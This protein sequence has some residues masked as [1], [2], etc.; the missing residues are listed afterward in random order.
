MKATAVIGANYGDEG[1]GR[2]VEWLAEPHRAAVLVVRSNGGAQAGHTVVAS[3]G[4]RHV[5]HHFGS[6]TLQG[7]R[8]HLSRFMVS[9]PIIFIEEF[10]QLHS[11]GTRPVVTADPRGFVTTPWDMMVNQAL[12]IARGSTRHGSCG[13]GF[14]ETVERCEAS[15]HRLSVADLGS[16]ELRGKLLAIRDEW[17]PS[18]LAHLQLMADAGP[19][20]F[21]ASPELFEAFLRQ[22]RQFAQWVP[23]RPDAEIGAEEIVIFEGAQGLL[24]DQS[25]SGFPY[26]TRSNTGMANIAVIAAE[27]GIL[28]VEPLYVTRCYLTRHGRGPMEDER[29]VARW[30]RTDDPTNCPNIW[31]ESLRFGLLDPAL[32]ASRIAEDLAG[33]KIAAT[34]A[35]ALTCLDEAVGPF[36]WMEAGEVVEGNREAFV[37]VFRSAAELPVAAMFASPIN[38]PVANKMQKVFSTAG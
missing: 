13:L 33:H 35:V 38:W 21:A 4:G 23:L 32:L 14:G 19:L 8:T 11:R 15:S 27:A 37:A 26:L 31:Q 25:A 34:P 9:H 22:C 6:G 2:T 24:L 28:E 1:K 3:D 20:A 18:R 5:F 36:A 10:A 16:R 12:E 30:Y 7:A 17:L 29:L